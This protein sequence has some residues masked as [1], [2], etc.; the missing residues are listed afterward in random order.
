[1]ALTISAI[2]PLY[3]GAQYI[4]AALA[5]I[6]RQ[7]VPPNEIIVVDDGSSDEGPEIVRMFHPDCTLLSQRNG[8]QSA[9]RNVGVRH[10]TG[11]L[12]AFLDQ[13]DI[14]YPHHLESLSV[15]FARPPTGPVLGWSYSDYDE[16]DREGR[17][18]CQGFLA[19]R[20]LGRPHPK[21]D[22]HDFLSTE[23]YVIPSAS[24]IS[25]SAFNAVGGFDERLSGYEDDD[26]FLRLF[27]AGYG[28]VFIS[29]ASA[30]WRL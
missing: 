12:I 17:L 29:T 23:I 15:P 16:I 1:M 24:L 13:D 5:S 20:S 21:R 8:G 14:W 28:N 11:D 30:Q 2:I 3:N 6:Q 26:L 18:V 10:A 9:A 4:R 22:L 27:R 19:L 7:T 25:R